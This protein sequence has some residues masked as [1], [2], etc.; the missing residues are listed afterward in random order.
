MLFNDDR[1]LSHRAQPKPPTKA[2][3]KCRKLK[4]NL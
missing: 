2:P 4:L 1:I 3:Y